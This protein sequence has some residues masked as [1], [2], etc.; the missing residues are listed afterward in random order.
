M[1]DEFHEGVVII[2][3]VKDLG[4]GIAP[5]NDMTAETANRGYFSQMEEC[6]LCLRTA[7]SSVS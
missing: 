3:L 1:A 6:P 4:L 5:I 2:V 7:A